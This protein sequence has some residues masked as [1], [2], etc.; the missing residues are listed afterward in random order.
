MTLAY[1]ATASPRT[2]STDFNRFN[3]VM[4]AMFDAL[5]D[6]AWFPTGTVLTA[7]VEVTDTDVA[8]RWGARD[9]KDG[10]DA[11]LLR[12]SGARSKARN[13]L[14]ISVRRGRTQKRN[15]CHRLVPEFAVAWRYHRGITDPIKTLDRADERVLG[16]WAE[17]DAWAQAPLQTRDQVHFRPTFPVDGTKFRR[18]LPAH[19][20]LRVNADG[21]HVVDCASSTGTV[22]ARTVGGWL[23][24]HGHHHEGVRIE[25]DLRRR[26]LNDLPGAFLREL[27]TQSFRPAKNRLSASMSSLNVLVPEQSDVDQLIQLW[28]LEAAVKFDADRGV[29]FGGYLSRVLPNWVQDLNRSSHGRT[30]ADHELRHQRAVSAFQQK[31]RRDPTD[32]ELAAVLGSD[33]ETLR[34]NAASLAVLSGL[35]HQQPLLGADEGGYEPVSDSDTAED[36]LGALSKALLSQSLVQATL[37][38]PDPAKRNP[39]GLIALYCTCWGEWTKGDLAKVGRTSVRSLNAKVEAAEEALRVKLDNERPVMR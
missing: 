2:K 13:D 35:R 9:R 4:C 8:E 3:P 27:C 16:G 32:H 37:G 6:G 12:A 5:I 31:H 26:N 18:M 1:T 36:L 21:Q 29:P 25:R 38:D 7:G 19:A 22:L 34:R 33:I 11:E 10:A 17:S 23:D 30:A 28:I 14:D 15:G 24:K 39:L 20:A